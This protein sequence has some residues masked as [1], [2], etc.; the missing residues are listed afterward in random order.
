VTTILVFIESHWIEGVTWAIAGAAGWLII[1]T[2]AKPLLAFWDDRQRAIEILRTDG[3][4]ACNASEDRV[5]EARRTT[6]QVAAR[7]AYYAEGGAAIVR[8][9]CRVRHYDLDL[10]DKT[11]RG[12]AGTVGNGV[13]NEFFGRQTD[14][15]RVCLGATRAMSSE[16]A[17]EIRLR[18]RE[19]LKELE[20]K[21]V[22]E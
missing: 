19:A 15:V 6:R 8:I 21:K 4:T 13:S 20:D 14:A 17:A 3:A 9:Y 18:L 12:L 2:I 7:L 16:R 1:N 11:L 5:L 22:S 10:A